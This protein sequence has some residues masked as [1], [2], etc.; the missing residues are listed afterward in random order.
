MTDEKPGQGE[1]IESR[2][3]VVAPV[4][5]EDKINLDGGTSLEVAGLSQ[6]EISQLRTKYAEGRIDLAHK[7]EELGL[8]VQALDKTLS[9]L[10]SQT[11]AVSE[12]GDSVTM[13]H[14]HT[15]TL[16]RTEV[17]MGN[18]DK[19]KSGKLTKSQSGED[20]HTLKYVMI[21]AAVIVV[22]ALIAFN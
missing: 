5:A 9:T 14:S 10:A 6:E 12:A 4:V 16:G 3:G 22:V 17:V 21:A 13:T 18:T 2:P 7:A 8:D 19:A 11:A 1:L 20:D 15:N